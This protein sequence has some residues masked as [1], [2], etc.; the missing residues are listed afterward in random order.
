MPEDNTLTEDAYRLAR[1][2]LEWQFTSAVAADQRAIGAAGMLVAAAAVLAALADSAA[3]P[4]ALLAGS[5][6]LAAAAFLAWYSARPSDFYVP[7]GKFSDLAEDI[8]AGRDRAEVLAE[9]G[10]FHDK[11]SDANDKAMR[12]CGR[13][14]RWAFRIALGSIA[15]TIA[16][17]VVALG[18]WV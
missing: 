7:G 17:Q 11:H 13:Q 18:G 9:L 5:A 8:A 1:E 10:A 3:A 14:M 2:R 15:V 6:G 12:R 16:G 4:A